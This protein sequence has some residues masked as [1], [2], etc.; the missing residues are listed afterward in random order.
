MGSVSS[1]CGLFRNL[2]QRFSELERE[3]DGREGDGQKIGHWLCHIDGCG[4]I[5]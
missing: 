5:R 3:K 4:L 2:L 1:F